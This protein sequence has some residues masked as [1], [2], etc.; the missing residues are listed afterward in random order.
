MARFYADI[1]GNRGEATRMGTEA[2]GISGHIRGWDIG[3]RVSVSVNDQGED[4]VR[5]RLTGGSGSGQFGL[6]KLIGIFTRKDLLEG[7]NER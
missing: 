3:A 6:G 2:S 4:E 7:R 1:K 5:V